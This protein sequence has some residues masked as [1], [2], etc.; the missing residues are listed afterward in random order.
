MSSGKWRP[1]C[2]GLN[3]LIKS[4][5]NLGCGGVMASHSKQNGGVASLIIPCEQQH[6]VCSPLTR[7]NTIL[8]LYNILQM[9]C[10]CRR[11]HTDPFRLQLHVSTCMITVRGIQPW[12]RPW[13]HWLVLRKLQFICLALS[14]IWFIMRMAMNKF[15]FKFKF[16][17]FIFPK[18]QVKLHISTTHWIHTG[19]NGR[20]SR[21]A[22]II[23]LLT[24][25]ELKN[26]HKRTHD[27]WNIKNWKTF[28]HKHYWEHIVY[29]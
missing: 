29:K 21:K 8:R 13:S 11:K 18:I 22:M 17:F 6:L 28:L 2:L 5:W 27:I 3:V 1:S 24:S 20:E 19:I 23:S 16:K 14:E 4:P 10:I 7:S 9:K 12:L 15:K 26:T 25:G